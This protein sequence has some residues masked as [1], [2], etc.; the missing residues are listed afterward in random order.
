MKKIL[1]VCALSQ[2][3]N[4]IKSNI[5]KINLKNTKIS[6][7]TTGMWNYNTILNLSRFLENNDFDF[8][9]N[10]WVCWYFE[11]KLDFF[12]VVRIFNIS[13]SKEL[14]LPPIIEFWEL[15]SILS[16]EKIVFDNKNNFEENFV[17]MESYWFEMVCDSFKI[18]RIILKIPVDKIWEETKKFD[19]EKA[20]K[21]LSENIEYNKLIEKINNYLQKQPD[22]ENFD[23]YFSHYN[24][25]FSEKQNFKKL[26]YRYK[27][28]VWDDFEVYFMQNN[29]VD[30]K[31][32]LKSLEN[33]LEKFLVK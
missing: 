2:E 11:Q 30:K 31:E 18:P 4:T 12:Q 17:D 23:L 22:V 15:Q 21:Y 32:F 19:F 29:F 8:V 16:S 9:V 24:F 1:I 7:F 10:I 27:S 5:K 3:L 20:K 14:I 33:F 6:F 26:F 28:L 13:N 25:T